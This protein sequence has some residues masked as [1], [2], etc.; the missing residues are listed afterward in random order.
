MTRHKTLREKIAAMVMAAGLLFAAAPAGA[1]T[2]L[3]FLQAQEDNSYR[4]VAV[5]KSLVI[6]F[7][8]QG[9][10]NVPDSAHL[11]AYKLVSRAPAHEQAAFVRRSRQSAGRIDRDQASLSDLLLSRQHPRIVGISTNL[12]LPSLEAE[13]ID[14]RAYLVPR[15]MDTAK[16][17]VGLAPQST[18]ES[19]TQKA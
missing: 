13:D 15:M 12:G 7:V 14:K 18:P 11:S 19:P 4:D 2:G 6:Q 16:R 1:M 5:M 10:R 17:A 8:S 3:E 9:Y